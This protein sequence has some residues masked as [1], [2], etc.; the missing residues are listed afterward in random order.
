MVAYI[1]IGLFPGFGGTWLYPRMLGS[2]G[3]AAEMLFTGDYMEAEEA[4]RLGFL[5]KLVPE[6]E[7]EAT[8]MEMAAE[9][10]QRPAGCH[11]PFKADCFTKGWSLTWTPP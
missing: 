7:L 6:D 3:K 2:I 9:N 4:Y 11:A 1:R 5:N 8:T 10:S